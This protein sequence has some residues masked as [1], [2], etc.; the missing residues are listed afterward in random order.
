MRELNSISVGKSHGDAV[1]IGDF[2]GAGFFRANE[3][4]RAA[5]VYNGSAVAGWS[6]GGN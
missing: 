3:V 2:V 1:I 4:D 5:R 6:E